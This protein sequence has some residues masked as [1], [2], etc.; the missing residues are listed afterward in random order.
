MARL[1]V[2][3]HSLAALTRVRWKPRITNY[4][5]VIFEGCQQNRLKGEQHPMGRSPTSAPW[6]RFELL[7][8]RAVDRDWYVPRSQPGCDLQSKLPQNG[9]HMHLHR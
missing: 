1:Y 8:F 5:G 7:R 9:L 3:H 4:R 2:G 6:F